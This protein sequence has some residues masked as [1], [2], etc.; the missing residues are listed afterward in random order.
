MTA[1]IYDQHAAAFARVSA[2]VVL[3]KGERVATVALKFPADGAG[4]LFAYV[5]WLGAPMVRAFAGGGGYDKR[6]AA[7]SAAA[8]KIDMSDRE[9]LHRDDEGAPVTP[10]ATFIQALTGRDG[11]DW[12]RKL[13]DAGFVVIQAV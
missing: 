10:R 2:F 8:C 5:H 12:T 3:D 9:D 6:S 4:R 13:E 1:N 11:Q 7:V